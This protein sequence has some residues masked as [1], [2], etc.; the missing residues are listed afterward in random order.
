[1]RFI[2]AYVSP[3]K[4]HLDPTALIVGNR[5]II[6]AYGM[7]TSDLLRLKKA[8]SDLNKFGLVLVD[9]KNDRFRFL[10]FG[11]V[12]IGIF[13]GFKEVTD[14]IGLPCSYDFQLKDISKL[15]DYRQLSKWITLKAS[16]R[17]DAENRVR[18]ISSL[19]EKTR[20]WKVLGPSAI[21][22][23]EDLMWATDVFEPLHALTVIAK[24]TPLQIDI[25]SLRNDLR[26]IGADLR[27]ISDSGNRILERRKSKLTLM[28]CAKFLFTTSNY[29]FESKSSELSKF[30][31]MPVH[32][33]PSHF[34]GYLIVDDNYVK[35]LKEASAR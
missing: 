26:K 11:D 29:Y 8:L 28:D 27:L 9:K 14:E 5:E 3:I 30:L 21:E 10:V 15:G 17:L 20:L 6:V 2:R 19:L 34:R 18:V 31:G 12:A 32:K 23:V 4:M 25:S 35:E 1:M 16:E 7:A 13:P 33:L 24:T 22:I